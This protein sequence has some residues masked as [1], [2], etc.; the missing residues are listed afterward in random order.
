MPTPTKHAYEFGPFRLTP[1]EGHLLREGNPVT[2]TPKAFEALVLLVERQGHLIEKEEL[3]KSLWPD[4]FVEEANLA[5]HVWRLRKALEDS[6]DVA[7]YIETVP[8]RGYR[9][10]APVKIIENSTPALVVEEHTVTRVVAERETEDSLD[11]VSSSAI[12]IGS[13]SRISITTGTIVIAACLL[14][15]VAAFAY[16]RFGIKG[17]TTPDG[18]GAIRTLAV[19]PFKPLTP[20]NSDASLEL[21]M[22]DALITRLSNLKELTVRPTSAVIKYTAPN[23]DLAGIG[24]E[25][26][27]Q[28]V[29]DGRVQRAGD[30]MRV[31]VQLVRTADGKPLWAEQFD[32]KSSDIFALEDSLSQKVARA[33]ALQLTAAE[34]SRIQQHYTNNIEAYHAYLRGRY[35]MNQAAA[36]ALKAEGSFEEA[37]QKDPR[38]A[39]AYSGLA[40]A[41][42]ALAFMGLGS[43]TPGEELMKAKDA[44]LKALELDDSLA[45]AHNSLA[46]LLFSNEWKWTEAEREFKRA[47]ELNPNLAEAHHWYSEYLQAMTRSDEALAEIKRAQELDPLSLTINFHYGLCLF[48]MGRHEEALVQFRRTLDIDP[49]TGAQGSHWGIAMVYQRRGMYEEAIRELEEARR[50]DPRPSWRL[51]GDAEAYALAGRRSEALAMLAQILEARKHQYVSPFAIGQIYAALGDKD[52]AF[53]WLNKAIDEREVIVVY[54]RSMGLSEPSLSSLRDDPRFQLLL[55]RVGLS[56]QG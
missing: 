38:F 14:V 54:L 17:T 10:I 29:L 6:K 43:G 47:I 18:A 22:A 50:L 40:D 37:I 24:H 25:L 20:D 1:A 28:T 33:L 3:M 52:Q 31:T 34:T 44:A 13:R 12:V 35:Q 11:A 19:L 27:V 5:H 26:N 32:E 56:F 30:R 45:E 41:H 4:T 9:F 36:G 53:V 23:S 39:L 16:V 51:T 21:G 8:K 2:L 7:Q 55:Q 48:G 42:S 15:L 49:T 46:N